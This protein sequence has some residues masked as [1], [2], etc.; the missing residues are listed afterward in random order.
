MFATEDV[1]ANWAKIVLPQSTAL[2]DKVAEI[3]KLNT[4]IGLNFTFQA[5][6]D[7]EHHC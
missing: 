1:I 6:N 2:K 3:E 4:K 7:G 5:V